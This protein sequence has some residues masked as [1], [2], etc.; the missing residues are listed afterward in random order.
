MIS[1]SLSCYCRKVRACPSVNP[2]CVTTN[3]KSS[4]FEFPWEIPSNSLENAVEVLNNL[5][6]AFFF[7]FTIKLKCVFIYMR[8][9]GLVKVIAIMCVVYSCYQKHMFCVG[10]FLSNI[11]FCA[12][13]MTK[14]AQFKQPFGDL[15]ISYVNKEVEIIS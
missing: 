15:K 10:Y 13:W 11:P 7:F 14:W 9:F 1:K 2:G 8:W 3:P 6:Y 5:Y 12:I 4:N